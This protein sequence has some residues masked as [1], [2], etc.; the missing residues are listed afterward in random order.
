ME[1]SSLPK[2]RTYV[3]LQARLENLPVRVVRFDG[4]FL[5][6]LQRQ[7]E[8]PRNGW[9]DPVDRVHV[10]WGRPGKHDVQA[11]RDWQTPAP[12]VPGEALT[13]GVG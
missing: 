10:R 7:A 12:E 1:P 13:F 8:T 6:N 5:A 3:A 4:G 2:P 9:L 11:G